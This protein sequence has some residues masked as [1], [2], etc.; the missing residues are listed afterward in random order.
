MLK[1]ETIPPFLPKEAQEAAGARAMLTQLKMVAVRQGR[2]QPNPQNIEPYRLRTPQL[3]PDTEADT[4][5]I[6]PKHQERASKSKRPTECPQN[7]AL[8][9]RN[10]TR[11]MPSLGISCST[12]FHHEVTEV[13]QTMPSVVTGGYVW[14]AT[15]LQFLVCELRKSIK[16]P[17]FLPPQPQNCKPLQAIDCNPPPNIDPTIDSS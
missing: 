8:R 3:H 10:L 5:T 9:A 7:P 1:V 11:R 14:R 16:G 6:S 12:A 17:Q 4:S 13:T 15:F 2:R